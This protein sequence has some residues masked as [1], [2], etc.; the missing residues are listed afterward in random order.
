MAG[1]AIMGFTTMSY[2][3]VESG[4]H[5]NMEVMLETVEEKLLSV[6]EYEAGL[7][8]EEHYFEYESEP[9]L[10]LTE[11]DAYLVDEETIKPVKSDIC[12]AWDADGVHSPEIH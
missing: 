1:L 8:E 2:A 7:M 9:E 12:N 10:E 4:S 3:W 11:E 5:D 6:S